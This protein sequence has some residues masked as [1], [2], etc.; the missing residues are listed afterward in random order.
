MSA[1]VPDLLRHSAG[2]VPAR[3][4][5]VGEETAFTFG[6]CHQRA[7]QLARLLAA[8][9]VRHG[10]RVAV[11]AYNE[12]E[13]FEIQV[14]CQ[15]AGAILVPLNYRLSTVELQAIYGDAEPVMLIHGRELAEPASLVSAKDSLFLGTDGHGAPYEREI[16]RYEPGGPVDDLDYDAV[17]TALYTSGT[18]GKP[19]GALVS[20]GNIFARVVAFD[21]ELRIGDHDRFLASLPM[22]HVGSNLAYAFMF[23]GAT[24]H[25][26]RRT[27]VGGIVD[28]LAGA[29]ITHTQFVPTVLR[30]VCQHYEEHRGTPATLR[31]ITYGGAAIDPS[32]LDRTLGLFG[33]CLRQWY[34][35]TETSACVTLPPENHVA[36]PGPGKLRTAGRAMQG[37]Q[38]GLRAEEGLPAGPGEVGEVLVRGPGVIK[39]Y[40]GAHAPERAL[41]GGWLHTGDLGV[42]DVEGFLTIVDRKSDV[43]ISGGENVYPREVEDVLQAHPAVERAAVLGIPDPHWGEIVHAVIT[44][45]EGM[46]VDEHALIAHVRGRLA[47]YKTPKSVE[48]RSDVPMTATEKIDKRALRA[49]LRPVPGAGAEGGGSGG[50]G[51]AR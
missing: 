4:C 6:E 8:R 26:M 47:G 51:G 43:I 48:F 9:G 16:A 14:A 41:V 35:S 15:R 10:D 3:L 27:T 31:S 33:S 19:K 38:L 23:Y 49:R 13:L 42:L 44:V 45:R 36:G 22:F 29:E 24:N 39:G 11:L 37:Y 7:S 30:G 5:A 21:A 40:L 34:G 2:R 12:P 25:V 1:K 18:T 46:A 20:N 17:A 32:L 50:E 28:R